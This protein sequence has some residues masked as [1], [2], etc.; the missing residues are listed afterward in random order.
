MEGSRIRDI[1]G[2]SRVGFGPNQD[3]T[4]QC[5]L[6]GGGTRNRQL[7]KSVE[8]VLGE[9][10]CW[11]GRVGRRNKK[12]ASKDEKKHRQNSEKLAENWK[13]LPKTGKFC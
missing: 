6:E 3:S 1:H 9:G 2:S 12:R 10:E 11:W 4:R 8:L 5:R 7:E 13:S